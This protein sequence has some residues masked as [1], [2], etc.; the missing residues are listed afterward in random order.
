MKK[1]CALFL[2]VV[3]SVSCLT[4]VLS[5][6]YEDESADSGIQL[7]ADTPKIP[8]FPGAEGAG[9][10]ATGGRGGEVYHVTNLNDSGKGSFRDAVSKSNRIVVF[11]VGGTIE[12]KSN[13]LVKGNVTIAGQTAPG[14]GGITLKNYK[15]GM[16]GDNIIVRFVSSRPG[17]S[18]KNSDA[19]AWGGSHGSLSMIDHC[20]L[21]WANDELFGLYSNNMYY[22][23][24]YSLIGPAN[25]WSYHSKGIHGYGM[26]FGKGQASWHH[27][28]IAH[29]V[30]RN[31]R[32][33]VEKTYVM[34][35]VNNVVYNWGYQTAY[36]TH[37]HTNYVNNYFKEGPSTR[38]GHNYVNLTSG[39]SPQN[40]MF[41]LTGNKMVDKTGKSLDIKADE[42]NWKRFN[43]G[44]VLNNSGVLDK[45]GNK[46]QEGYCKSDKRMPLYNYG[47]ITVKDEGKKIYIY[48]PDKKGEDLS[49]L[50]SGNVDTADEAFENV[51][52][53][54]GA[55]I[56]AESRPLIDA[57][58]MEEAR[59]GTGTISGA[60]PISEA[61]E[62]EL[63]KIKEYGIQCGVEYVYPDN[64]LEKEIVDSDKDGMPDEWEIARGLNPKDASDA[65][66]NYLKGKTIDGMC[67]EYTN[68]EYYINDLTVDA[69]PEGV[70]KESPVLG[71]EII[72]DPSAD[73]SGT[74]FKTVEKA[75]K[76]I[77]ENDSNVLGG[78]NTIYIVPGIYDENITVNN[79]NVIM[80]P[81]P[82]TNGEIVISKLTVGADAENF[83]ANGITFGNG[84]ADATVSVSADRAVFVKCGVKGKDN[85]VSLT[86]NCR[87]YFEN[88]DIYG[89]NNI[90][91]G[92]ARAVFNKCEVH[93][94]KNGSCVASLG[95]EA[96]NEYGFLF[97]DSIIT[98]DSSSKVSLGRPNGE[99]SQIIYKNCKMDSN[100][101]TGE[102]RFA[103]M[104]AGKKD[105]VRFMECDSKDMSGNAVGSSSFAEYETV[106]S[107]AEFLEKYNPFNHLKAKYG[108]NADNWNPGNFDEVTPQ[109]KL[110]S[111][112]DSITL[113]S[114]MIMR[115]TPV[116]S[117]F[118]DDSEVS[119]SWVS[120]DESCF[121]NNT[122]L[123]GEYGGGFKTAVLTVTVSK[124]GLKSIVKKFNIIVGSL[125]LNGAGVT[126]FEDEKIEDA[127]A[128]IKVSADA[129][130]KITWNITDNINGQKYSDK[131]KFF[132]VKQSGKTDPT[133]YNFNYSFE[134]KEEKVIEAGFD[135]YAGDMSE[136][137]YFEVM[138]RGQ[139]T[140][141][142]MRFTSD[143][144]FVNTDENSKNREAITSVSGE[145]LKFKMVIDTRG[146]LAGKEPKA[147]YYLYDEDGV[148]AS[149]KN[150]KPANAYSIEN[151]SRFI[152]NMIQFRPNRTMEKCEFYIDN[153]YFK[154]LSAIAKEDAEAFSETM[155]MEGSDRLPA[156][157]NHLSDIT[158]SVVDGQ[159]D[160]LN[161]DG[162]IN[163]DKCKNAVIRAKGTVKLGDNIKASA[164]TSEIILI[165]T[166]TGED[167]PQTTSKFFTDNDDFSSWIREYNTSSVGILL[168]DK[169]DVSGNSTEKI[170]LPDKAVFK[171][172]GSPVGS[173]TVSFSTDFLADASGRTFRIYFENAATDDDGKGYG[174]AAFGSDSIFYHLT[175]IGG[176]TYVVTSD[177]P[178][179]DGTTNNPYTGK[180]L[181]NLEPN[182]WYRI[183]VDLDLDAKKA[184]TTAYMHGTDG[185]YA[186]E[187]L[188]NVPVGKVE[189]EFISKAPLQLKQV[190]LV[191]TAKG[192]VIY[193][194]NVSLQ[195][196]TDVTGVI[197]TK[198]TAEIGV[199]DTLQLYAVV[200]PSEALNKNVSWN[201]SNDKVVSVDQNGLVTGVASGT[202]VITATTEEGRFTAE[203]N[204]TVKGSGGDVPV[205]S[206]GDVDGDG[207]V[208]P[209]DAALVLQYVLNKSTEG[210]AEDGL[211]AAKVTKGEQITALD[212]AAILKKALQQENFK[213]EIE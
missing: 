62:S 160:L 167:N 88:C 173:G 118:S 209:K 17:E 168:D 83:S 64:F 196:S 18:G 84:S 176:V 127:L 121:K 58:V 102:S 182:K 104:S 11:D 90:V 188:S 14:G 183:N 106:L 15:L 89:G 190:R 38:S 87:V 25:S 116:V 77:S 134:N 131:G 123:V 50:A 155:Y 111:L 75:V 45:N 139:S 3:L 206:L 113:P 158:W 42:D 79:A 2:S 146:V 124:E 105:K 29:N 172:L 103:D 153:L 91:S 22:T 185:K 68:I 8:A 135:V 144:V 212:A 28:M 52:K 30:S 100:V 98:G 165:I 132:A 37:G 125:T 23:V 138:F 81:K 86:D 19:D 76:Y 34:D 199:G 49:V 177:S 149:V 192:P 57:Q 114:G 82:D 97:M 110:Q 51:I 200:S 65:K 101:L 122:I 44:N 147:D 10:Y 129:S 32:G 71:S 26:M 7:E 193:F 142:Q 151:A 154:D 207:S 119:V 210:F 13:V 54:A 80:M 171:K 208:A 137:G 163:Y 21:G 130:D 187:N 181:G 61:D 150:A 175:D 203:C 35:Y 33:K 20:S 169:T 24:Q 148:I 39:S 189:S 162:T 202:A 66:G 201:S 186:P 99:Y 211:D 12:L 140:I 60:R 179:A 63:I 16:S 48:N 85:A 9:K 157:G 136:D 1:F 174:T 115:D 159:T 53:Y 78:N 41:Y 4:S 95:I 166:G 47:S 161:S 141:G 107:E 145:W 109:E 74:N 184:V 120:S 128:H 205:G 27:N 94:N 112:A 117:S 152:P 126:D 70:V 46:L 73:E 213:F 96:N 69:F 194:D 59:T 164:E 108:S 67:T 55:G 40:Y 36:G 6:N 195:G 156:Y 31:Y 92:K 72:V 5:Q 143:A 191:K 133:T 93:A 170:K 197:L 198:E 204:V 43:Y 56:N 178:R 180:A